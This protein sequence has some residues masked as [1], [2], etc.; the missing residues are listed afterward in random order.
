MFENIMS[1]ERHSV[2]EELVK[3]S[4]PQNFYLA[5]GTAAAL[6][7]GHRWS[8]DLD[9]F[10]EQEFDLFQLAGKLANIEGFVLTGQEPGTLHCLIKDVKVSFL[11]Y[12]YPL[13]GKG[14]TYKHLQLAELKDIALMKLVALV[15]RGTR[16]DFVDLYFLDKEQVSFEEMLR[17]Y[18]QK[19]PVGT[20]QPVVLLKSFGY[21][22][23][24]EKEEMPK[25]FRKVSWEEIKKHFLQRQKE[26]TMDIIEGKEI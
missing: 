24:A 2:L 16:K 11:Y 21:F 14:Q 1:A 25:M 10:T 19:Y 15:Q 8:E 6:Y 5:G 17:L 7:L 4:L 3:Q 9:F 26:L 12:P 20:Y 18:P 13:L 23:D 22:D